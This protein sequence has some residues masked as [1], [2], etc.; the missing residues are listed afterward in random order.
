MNDSARLALVT[1]GAR[2]L[3][4]RLVR[5]LAEEGYRVAFSYHGGEREAE[6]LVDEG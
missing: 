4:A 6:A 1:G 3:G 2:R 5:A